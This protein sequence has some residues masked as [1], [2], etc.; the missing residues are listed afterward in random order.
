MT[1]LN[2]AIL[3]KTDGELETA[4]LMYQ[5]AIEIW[6]KKLGPEHPNTESAYLNY[7]ILLYETGE[8]GAAVP[9]LESVV[10]TR[11]KRLGPDNRR[12]TGPLYHLAK[13][14][15]AAGN[16]PRTRA[17]LERVLK[18]DET[19]YGPDHAEVAADLDFDRRYETCQTFWIM[20]RHL[21]GAFGNPGLSPLLGRAYVD[22]QD[23][24]G[25]GAPQRLDRANDIAA[26]GKGRPRAQ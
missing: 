1:L 2:L 20:D 11:G 3:I 23:L 15:Q 26:T 13:A 16:L 25:L 18:L 17:L 22:Q 12:M 24:A 14:E 9:I 7:G 5:R 21:A 6:E 8:A 19:T 10:A 4:R